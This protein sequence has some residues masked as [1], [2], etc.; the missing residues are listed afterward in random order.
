MQVGERIVPVDATDNRAF[1]A[2]FLERADRRFAVFRAVF[3]QQ[4]WPGVWHQRVSTGPGKVKKTVV[5]SPST[6]SSQISPPCRS[7]TFLVIASPTPVPPPKAS[8][9]CRRLKIR[10]TAS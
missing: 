6:E 8:R 9:L 1:E 10:N 7:T 4:Q 2:G 5:P 3:N